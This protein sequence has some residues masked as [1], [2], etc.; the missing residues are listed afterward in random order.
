MYRI[1]KLL[2]VFVMMFAFVIPVNAITLDFNN[3]SRREQMTNYGVQKDNI[4]VSKAKSAILSTPV[5]DD[6]SLKVYDYSDVLT[7]DEEEILRSQLREF[8][9]QNKVE[10]IVVFGNFAQYGDYSFRDFAA[11]FYDFN[12]F[13]LATNA[14]DGIILVRDT[15]GRKDVIVTTGQTRL[16]I[17]DYRVNVISDSLEYPIVNDLYLQTGEK[18]LEGVKKCYAMGIPDEMKKY[19]FDENGDMYVLYQPPILPAIFLATIVDAIIMGILIKKNR[20]VKPAKK[21]DD[22]LDKA[23]ILYRV[24]D[25]K[26]IRSHTSSYTV[27]HNSGGGGHSGG[28]FRGSSGIS[29]G[30][31]GVR[32]R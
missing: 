12:G 8:Y 30:G 3:A 13:G 25:D 2:L 24:N 1:K 20:M 22:Y 4:D 27:S 6:T 23:S 31:G 11:N 19:Q 5:V 7:E 15:V 14:Y 10:V 32:H 26:F 9:D 18:F 17:D 28:G 29:H 16:Y 21:A